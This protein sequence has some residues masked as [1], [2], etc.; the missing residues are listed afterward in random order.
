MTL[1]FFAKKKL[2][3]A[4]VWHCCCCFCP[5][6]EF[7]WYSAKKHCGTS[8]A[9][10]IGTIFHKFSWLFKSLPTASIRRRCRL[11]VQ[12][13]PFPPSPLS[14]IVSPFQIFMKQQWGAW[15]S[16][17]CRMCLEKSQSLKKIL[18]WAQ[19]KSVWRW[20]ELFLSRSKSSRENIQL[21]FSDI[22]HRVVQGHCPDIATRTQ[23]A[24]PVVNH[25]S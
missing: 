19:M 7:R 5:R 22:S 4:T 9:N 11:S 2:A 18:Y 1:Y 25:F 20:F 15:I 23:P 14:L 8:R 6:D 3:A 12:K 13:F 10:Y 21:F 17:E 24:S 16:T